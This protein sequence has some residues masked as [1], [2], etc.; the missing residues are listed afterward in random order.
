VRSLLFQQ[1][2]QE[3]EVVWCPQGEKNIA[4]RAD[5]Q[6]FD[7]YGFPLQEANRA[8]RLPLNRT[9]TFVVRVR[10]GLKPIL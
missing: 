7:L 4:L 9:P 3:V 1:G 6:V 2:Q 10:K 8:K 5:E